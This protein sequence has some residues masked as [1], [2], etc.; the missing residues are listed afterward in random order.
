MGKITT[1]QTWLC[2]VCMVIGVSFQSCRSTD[3]KNTKDVGVIEAKSA[4][5]TAANTS[6]DLALTGNACAASGGLVETPLFCEKMDDPDVCNGTP[7]S[8]TLKCDCKCVAPCKGNFQGPSEMRATCSW[9]GY[10]LTGHCATLT[11]QRPTREEAQANCSRYCAAQSLTACTAPSPSPTPAPSA[12]PVPAPNPAVKCQPIVITDYRKPLCQRALE[13]LGVA[14]SA[15]AVI[16]VGCYILT[17]R[18]APATIGV[19]CPVTAPIMIPIA[20]RPTL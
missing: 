14:A 15:G 8:Q 13:T 20:C 1:F 4:E 7:A 2:V 17:T 5:Q 16:G 18:V 6:N 9:K 3:V 19:C 10:A 11:I 12:V